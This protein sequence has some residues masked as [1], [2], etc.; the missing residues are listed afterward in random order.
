MK[1]ICPKVL[2]LVFMFLVAVSACKQQSASEAPQGQGQG[3]SG[4]PADKLVGE[5]RDV[6]KFSQGNAND[7]MRYGL[8]RVNGKE[9]SRWIKT[10]FSVSASFLATRTQTMYK[11]DTC[12]TSF[13]ASDFSAKDYQAIGELDKKMMTSAYSTQI[14]L[15]PGE[16]L[17]KGVYAIDFSSPSS[18]SN[19]MVL[20]LSYKIEKNF[21]YIAQACSQGLIEAGSCSLATGD[22]P[23][24]RALNFDENKEPFPYI[25][26]R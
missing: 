7:C 3:A 12:K 23:T 2:F 18:Q 5:W 22:K 4:T 26:M 1:D 13:S 15:K 20:Y 14:Q 21:L 16:Q 9:I 8:L 24:N 25:Y 19:G 11:D 10:R 6:M 17:S